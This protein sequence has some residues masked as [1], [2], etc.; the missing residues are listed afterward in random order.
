MAIISSRL[1]KVGLIR[2]LI[3][4]AYKKLKPIVKMGKTELFLES[5]YRQ[6]LQ[7]Y[8]ITNNIIT[9]P[10]LFPWYLESSLH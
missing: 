9:C 3:L 2:K 1:K 6:L 4:T 7:V 5:I 10:V 8:N